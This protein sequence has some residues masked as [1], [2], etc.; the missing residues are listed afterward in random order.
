LNQRPYLFPEGSRLGADNLVLHAA[1]RR[2]K[3]DELAGP[4][5]IKTV[6]RGE[7]GWRVQGRE[8]VVDPMAF[9]VLGLHGCWL[10]QPVLLY[11]AVPRALRCSAI[12]AAISQES[13][14]TLLDGH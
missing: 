5:S 4:L 11:E 13:T 7:V 6:I 1:A 9:L 12:G 14:R 3:L 8:I 2:H 10:Q